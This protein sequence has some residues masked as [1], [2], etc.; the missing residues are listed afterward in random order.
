MFDLSPDFDIRVRGRSLRAE[1]AW[2]DLA[3]SW[4]WPGGCNEA[5]FT[6][7][8]KY[9]TRIAS[10][11]RSASAEI[12]WAGWPIF[13]GTILEPEWDGAQVR[14]AVQGAFKEG[15]GYAPLDGPSLPTDN[16]YAAASAAAGFRGLDWT[17]DASIPNVSLGSTSVYANLNG[18]ADDH[19]TQSGLR[20]AVNAQRVAYMAADPTAVSYHVRAGAADLG[21]ATDAYASNVVLLYNDSTS[22]TVQSAVYP[23][24]SAAPSVYEQTYGHVEWMTDK[25]DQAPM[26]NATALGIA[27]AVYERSK[28]RPGF[29]NGLALAQGEIVDAGWQ[30][31]HPARVASEAWGKVV[32]VHGVPDMALA[33]PYTDFVVGKT[34]YTA[35]SPTV[36]VDPVGLASRDPE[37]VVTELIEAMVK[38]GTLLGEAA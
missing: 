35:G 21:I 6:A 2:G 19:A 1:T 36:G 27:Q 15:V 12:T 5:S 38:S 3:M 7:A 22:G 4:T 25:T 29:T 11:L 30:P 33:T 9:G 37:S 28:Q 18:L 20:W 34:A 8:T 26:S 16:I 17:I 14:V 23:D 13:A 31:I 10:L 24:L 32:R